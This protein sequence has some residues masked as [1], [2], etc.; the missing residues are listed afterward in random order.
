MAGFGVRRREHHAVDE[1]LNRERQRGG[2]GAADERDGHLAE[3]EAR[4]ASAG[5]VE[6]PTRV[7]G[8]A[9]EIPEETG[10]RCRHRGPS[11]LAPE[12]A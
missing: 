3:E 9:A 11:V 12:G 2:N 1:V 5:A 7:V 6:R 10:G 8:E 4:V